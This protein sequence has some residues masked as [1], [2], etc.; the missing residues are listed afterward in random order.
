MINFSQF[1][2]ATCSNLEHLNEINKHGEMVLKSWRQLGPCWSPIM[3]GSIKNVLTTIKMLF[4]LWRTNW[5]IALN[6][7]RLQKK[8]TQQKSLELKVH[9]FIANC[10][11][12]FGGERLPS[13]VFWRK[14]LQIFFWSPAGVSCFFRINLGQIILLKNKTLL[15]SDFPRFPRRGKVRL[16]PDSY[17]FGRE[18]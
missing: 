15:R 8:S 11:P 9:R 13:S 1:H 5:K 3:P 14:H 10:L 16:I 2:L 17:C 4:S 7:L 18:V 6:Q 12:F